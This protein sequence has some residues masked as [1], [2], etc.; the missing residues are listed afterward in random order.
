[1]TFYRE[2]LGGE[3]HLQ[4]V[5][6][7][8]LVELLPGVMKNCILHATLKSNNLVLMGTDMVGET[9]LSRGNAVS[10]MINCQNQ[11]EMRDYFLRLSAGA[12]TTH[13]IAKT[14]R[15]AWLG[16]LTDKFGNPWLLTCQ[17]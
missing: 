11:Q 16:T 1:M 15:G 8:A 9:G 5:G 12:E 17:Q 3:L 6:E 13:P 14:S 10:I 4:T 7:S 2:C